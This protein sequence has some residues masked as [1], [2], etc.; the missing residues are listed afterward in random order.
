WKHRI[1]IAHSARVALHEATHRLY[2]MNSATPGV[3]YAISTDNHAIVGTQTLPAEGLALAVSNDGLRLFAAVKGAPP[4]DDQP[5]VLVFDVAKWGQADAQIQS[6]SV[7]DTAGGN[8]FLAV[9][10]SPDNRLLALFAAPGMIAIWGTDII[11][12]GPTALPK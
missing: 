7:Q 2:V 11:N 8:V 4:P 5:R 6:L 10:P 3:I 1:S 9:A 12:P